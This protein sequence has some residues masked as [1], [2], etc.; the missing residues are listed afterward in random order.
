MFLDASKA[1]DV[2]NH[3]VLADTL[4]NIVKDPQL[5]Q[6]VNTAYS[7]I[8][9]YVK[10]E[11][12]RGTSFPVKQGV[13]QGG[14][15]S[16]PLYKLYIQPLLEKLEDSKLG[17]SL[18]GAH[19][20]TPTCADDMVLMANNEWDLQAMIDI[21]ELFASQRRYT[22][23]P[24]KSCV[25]HINQSGDDSLSNGIGTERSLLIYHSYVYPVFM[26]GLESMVLDKRSIDTLATFHMSIIKELQG[27][28]TRC[29]NAAAYL[30]ANQ[31]PL[32]ALL[33]I[34]ILTLLCN[35]AISK[36]NSL[37]ILL[38]RQCALRVRKSWAMNAQDTL[39][40]YD[41]GSIDDI[42]KS[43]NPRLMK[44]HFK[45]AIRKEWNRRLKEE[46]ADKSS[47]RWLHLPPDEQL[48]II[49]SDT[50][51]PSH[52]RKATIKARMTT[53]CYILQ[54][55]VKR[56]NQNEVNATCLL[57]DIGEPE[58][59]DHFLCRCSYPPIKDSR[60]RF[61]PRLIQLLHT[62]LGFE[63]LD[64]QSEYH[65]IVQLVLDCTAYDPD[66]SHTHDTAW[67][68][69]ES[70][71]REYCYELHRLRYAAVKELRGSQPCRSRPLLRTA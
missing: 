12:I 30:M 56:F 35:I 25:L 24:T 13:R 37:E 52:T 70:H 28:P 4:N 39:D 54:A 45:Q 44:K 33:H 61:L 59:I 43:D 21:T 36:N 47:L 32:P 31:L 34:A 41:M 14:T 71:A 60:E 64:E 16:A 50:N 17:L 65:E 55:D 23:H 57:C 69:L 9:S 18:G 46:C 6:A 10:W 51:C 67:L 1:F 22:L 27:L 48:H 53:G 62:A 40:I 7:D 66:E 5:A 15:L 49:W 8:S 3:V 11:H 63:R 20:G 68:A 19:I 58:N 42:F 26:Y 2:V 29:A 38:K